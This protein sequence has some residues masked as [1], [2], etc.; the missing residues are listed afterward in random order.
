MC[1]MLITASSPYIASLLGSLSGICLFKHRQCQLMW[2][3]IATTTVQDLWDLQYISAFYRRPDEVQALCWNH[4]V[5]GACVSLK[6]CSNY[7]EPN[8]LSPEDNV[9]Q[10][11]IDIKSCSDETHMK[12]TYLCSL[13]IMQL[14]DD[15]FKCESLHHGCL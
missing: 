12:N 7:W 5:G 14:R 6:A 8:F 4:H 10:P 9:I 3:I 13:T 2:S 1:H 15:S 11:N